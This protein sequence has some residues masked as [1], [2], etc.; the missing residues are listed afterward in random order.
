MCDLGNLEG[1][2]LDYLPMDFDFWPLWDWDNSQDFQQ[3]I[4]SVEVPVVMNEGRPLTEMILP[5]EDQ[6]AAPRLSF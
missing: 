5:Y 4:D 2:N 1:Q 3:Q 6:D